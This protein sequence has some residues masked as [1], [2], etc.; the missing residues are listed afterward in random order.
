VRT[1]VLLL[2]GQQ[3]MHGYQIIQAITER[4]QGAW[5]PSPGAVYPTLAQ[6][7]DE[8]LVAITAEGG[9]KLAELTDAGRDHLAQQERSGSDPFA[10]HTA[11]EG[12]PDL[13]G[14]LHGVREAAR[15]VGAV[16]T[17]AQVQAAADLL[18][19]TRRGLYL[20]LATDPHPGARPAPGPSTTEEPAH[21]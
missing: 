14:L 2:L 6:L 7:E 16:G 18:A 5:R 20:I 21:D 4:T 15:Q 17:P 12:G 8:G 19:E 13:R 3:P 10:E 1:A 9:R 11:T